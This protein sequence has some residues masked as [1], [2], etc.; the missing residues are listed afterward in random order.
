M[1]A[2]SR[3]FKVEEHGSTVKREILAGITTF[4]TMAYILVVNPGMLSAA[5]GKAA[6][7]SIL[8]ATALSAGFA[9][10]LM[11]IYANKPF[12]LAAGMGLN[13]YF[14]FTVAPQYGWQVALAAVFVEGLIFIVLSLTSVR[15]AVAHSIPNS[16][17]HAIGA[18]IGIFLT[19][20]GLQH[21]GFIAPDQ[22]T[23]VSLGKSALAK[24]EFLI[25]VFG[26]ILASVLIKLKVPGALLITI[27]VNTIIGMVFGLI[28]IP[29]KLFSL[30]TLDYTFLKLDFH[31][32]MNAGALGVI[33][34]FFMVD[35]FDTLGTVTGLSAKAGYLTEDGKIPDI[36][37]VLLT[38]AVGTTVGALLGTSTVTTYIESA[39][40]IEEGGRTGLTAVTTGIL[41][42]LVG[43]FISPL[44]AVIK[45]FVTAPVLVLVGYFMMST[46]FEVDFSDPSEAIPAFLVLVTIPFT[47]SIADGIGVGFITYTLIKL[48]SGKGKDVHPLMYVLA[49]I[50][51]LYFMYLGGVF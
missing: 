31:G 39:S 44:V 30:P 16:L 7:P 10:I 1:E 29:S 38:D 51:V 25:A 15:S 34:S 23:M 8:T 22:A 36:D 17:K 47:Y 42:L 24:P 50:F 14:A 20:I 37:K 35:F 12:A 11:G 3:F 46:F 2:I 49:I 5:M 9:T 26:L 32:L 33:F 48:L 13:A 4:M 40:G 43:L 27:I 28:D 21:M 6:I 19:F 41:F 18:G 45:D